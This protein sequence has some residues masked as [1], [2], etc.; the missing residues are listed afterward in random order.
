MACLSNSNKCI[1]VVKKMINTFT[2]FIISFIL[3]INSYV[4]CSSKVAVADDDD[5]T[6]LQIG[7]SIQPE[8]PL[9]LENARNQLEKY[10]Q[11]LPWSMKTISRREIF[12]VLGATT[13]TAL[14]KLIAGIS[15]IYFASLDVARTTLQQ[16]Q[17]GRKFPDN[18]TLFDIHSVM[19]NQ[20]IS[21]H[22]SDYFDSRN[23]TIPTHYQIYGVSSQ[24]PNDFAF[25]ASLGFG[26]AF[27]ASGIIDL[28]SSGYH[29]CSFNETFESM[30][31]QTLPTLIDKVDLNETTFNDYLE[32]AWGGYVDTS[33]KRGVFNKKNFKYFLTQ[34]KNWKEPRHGNA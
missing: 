2:C 9:T 23:N 8:A 25:N 7:S 21:I 22:S 20:I 14:P 30:V 26:I 6:N 34:Y 4:Y 3:S 5:D 1:K 17:I 28:I 11:T 18:T 13:T 24:E 29:Q 16:D 10:T 15:L 32:Y 19:G 33:Q 31:N 27:F 12:G